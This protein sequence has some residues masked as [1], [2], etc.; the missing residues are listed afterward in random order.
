MERTNYTYRISGLLNDNNRAS[1]A[2]VVRFLKSI[3]M[4]N[5]SVAMIFDDTQECCCGG[6]EDGWHSKHCNKRPHP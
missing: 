4:V 2:E 1:E 5:I 6:K 3:G